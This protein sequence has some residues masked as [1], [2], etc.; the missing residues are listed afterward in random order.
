MYSIEEYDIIFYA[1]VRYITR[2][3]IIVFAILL[4][5][6]PLSPTNSDFQPAETRIRKGN[7]G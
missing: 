3:I 1:K 4:S 2:N 5:P 7:F 6:P